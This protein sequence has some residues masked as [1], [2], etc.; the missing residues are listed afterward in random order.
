MD[1]CGSTEASVGLCRPLWVSTNV[2]GSL[3]ASEGLYRHTYSSIQA[4]IRLYRLIWVCTDLYGALPTY[5][6]VSAGL[7]GSLQMHMALYRLIWVAMDLAG[8]YVLPYT[9]QAGGLYPGPGGI[10][11]AAK[12]PFWC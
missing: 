2:Y 6:W 7:Y 9:F 11:S 1:L 4:Y 5:I 10:I 12:K 3:Q 8:L